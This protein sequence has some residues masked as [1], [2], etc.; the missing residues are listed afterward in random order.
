MKLL[1][2]THALLWWLNDDGKL[3]QQ[4]RELIADPGND[5]L[6]SVV[7]LWEVLVKIRVGKLE[8][9][10]GHISDA[11][12]REGFTRLGI[13][14][15][16]LLALGGLPIRPDHRDPFDHLLIAQAITEGATFISEDC[17]V[18]HYPVQLV[19]CSDSP[20]PPPPR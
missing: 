14:P 13:E 12:E 16:H 3:G 9:H 17:N 6:V 20:A 2:D 18:P 4:A 7:S 19:T 1:L 5:V 15:A 11:I 10:I 8:A